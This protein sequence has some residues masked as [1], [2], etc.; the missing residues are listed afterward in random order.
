MKISQHAVK[1]NWGDTDQAAIVYYPNYFAWFDQGTTALMESVGLDWDTSTRK[2]SIVGMPIV[3]ARSRF[4]GPCRFRDSLIV[5][6]C[7]TEWNSRTF[8]I[9]HKILNRGTAV[10]EGHEVRVLAKAH[11]DDPTRILAC[12]IPAEFKEA[13]E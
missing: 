8:R 13:F 2:F 9:S 1:V 11:P 6:S 12:A 5:E 10:A 3:E 4:M 7:I